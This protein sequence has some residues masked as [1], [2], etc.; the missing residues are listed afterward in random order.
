MPRRG[1]CQPCCLQVERVGHL[2]V[3]DP[4]FPVTLESES[5]RP[6]LGESARQHL[7]ESGIGVEHLL[8]SSL[9]LAEVQVG[10]NLRNDTADQA[11]DQDTEYRI[12]RNAHR[13]R[14]R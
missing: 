14:S 1:Y 4:T 13:A 12:G 7:K 10:H 2:G 5:C 11:A 8:G 6:A 9:L 3:D